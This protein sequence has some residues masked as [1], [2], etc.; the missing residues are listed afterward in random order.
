MN[1]YLQAIGWWNLIGSILMLFFLHQSF[2]QKLLVEWSQIFK[3]SYSLSYYGKLWLFWAAGL[4]IIF[5][6]L[7]IMASYW[8]YPEI[9]TFYIRM[10]IIA[11][12]LFILLAVWGLLAERCGPG[13]YVAFIIFSIWIVWGI[14][15]L[16]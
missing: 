5:G 13:I 8:N 16:R 12:I 4:N 9:K 11:Y 15:A 14:I 3:E 2:A 7:N 1:L 10:D 6:L